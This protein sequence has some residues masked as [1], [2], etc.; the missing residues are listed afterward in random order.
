MQRHH[1]DKLYFQIGL[2][3]AAK[4]PELANE[5]VTKFLH[6]DALDEDLDNVPRYREMYD[7]YLQT[8]SKLKSIFDV[9]RLFASAMLRIYTPGV[10]NQK[11]KHITISKYG[12][13]KALARAI[14][15]QEPGA[16]KIV[17]RVINEEKI[18]EDYRTEVQSLVGFLT[19]N[20]KAKAC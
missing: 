6:I 7:D 17:K 1:K 2:H 4:H 20:I 10:Y 19:E 12:F 15:V 3:V 8:A 11:T 14:G 13:G 16:S 18:Y 9:R 5:I